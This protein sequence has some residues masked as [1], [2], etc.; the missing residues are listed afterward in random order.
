MGRIRQAV[1][2][3]T[4]GFRKADYE[5][6]D[7]YLNPGEKELFLQLR[8]GEILHSIAVAKKLAELIKTAFQPP[9]EDRECFYIIKAGLM[10]DLGKIHYG[11]NVLE[12]T[13]AV[14]LDK[15]VVDRT[16]LI[17]RSRMMEIYYRHPDYSR[18]LALAKESF[19]AY[20]YLYKVIALH[21]GKI[22]SGAELNLKETEVWRL[23]HTADDES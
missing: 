21:H 10:H 6:V 17:V 3:V 16:K 11:M 1:M 2:D 4:A 22:P 19:A 8:Q 12:K 18:G 14:L 23:L 9:L 20:P 7:G 13:M 15:L 5:F